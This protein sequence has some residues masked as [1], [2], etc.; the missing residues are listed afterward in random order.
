M[1]GHIHR[2]ETTDANGRRR[3]RWYAVV[4]LPRGP[5]GRRRQKWHGGYATRRDAELARADVL[6]RLARGAYIERTSMSLAEWITGSWL[7][8]AEMQ[9]KATTLHSYRRNLELHLLPRLGHLRLGELSPTLLTSTYA[10]LFRSGRRRGRAKG[11]GLSPTTIHYLHAILHR[12]LADAVTAGLLET[13]PAS[14]ARVPKQSAT[15]APEQR[16]WTAR[17]L[18]LF[19]SETDHH[20]LSL[21]WRLAAMTGMRRG[22]VLG[23]RWKDVDL[24]ARR[25]LVTRSVVVVGNDAVES[26]PKNGRAR[27]VDLD[28][29]TALLLASRSPEHVDV[30]SRVVVDT[31]G[32]PP[33]P[34]GLSR[35]FRSAIAISGVPPIRFHDLRHTH[36]TL[37]LASGVPV[38]VVAE[39]LGHSSPAFTLRRYAHVLPGMQAAAAETFAGLVAAHEPETEV[40]PEASP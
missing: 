23:L 26:T 8:M 19:L 7:E 13:N 5:D 1:K 38:R 27:V 33:S 20:P 36:A 24:D 18:A 12:A 11:A 2:R 35:A 15:P 9:L 3:V 14:R 40:S 10:E 29:G 31:S 34:G 39:R 28:A 32:R 22:E 16:C 17:E 37:S 25:L 4:D 6:A 30:G 21:A